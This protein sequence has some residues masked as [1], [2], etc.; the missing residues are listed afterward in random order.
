MRRRKTAV[1]KWLDEAL[2]ADPDF[3]KAVDEMLQEMRHEQDE[4][5][6][7]RES[8]PGTRVGRRVRR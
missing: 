3:A 7:S 2:R 6:R 5:E 8:P 4:L 1:M